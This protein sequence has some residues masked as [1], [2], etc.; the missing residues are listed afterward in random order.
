MGLI[1]PISRGKQVALV[2]LA[3]NFRDRHPPRS[4]RAI[5]PTVARER[6]PLSLA[7]DTPVY[8]SRALPLPY[9]SRKFSSGATPLP[10]A[11]E[12][13]FFRLLLTLLCPYFDPILTSFDHILT[14]LNNFDLFEP[15]FTLF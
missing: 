14:F 13:V 5:P 4:S 10:H 8:R 9:R 7:S 11:R 1:L 3:E 15:T 2:S 6:Y 12:R